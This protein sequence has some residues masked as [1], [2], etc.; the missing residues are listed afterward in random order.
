MRP[1]TATRKR[2]VGVPV[3]VDIEIQLRKV[4]GKLK[5]LPKTEKERAYIESLLVQLASAEEIERKVLEEY[6][7]LQA[8]VESLESKEPIDFLSWLETNP[9]PRSPIASALC[10]LRGIGLERE[11]LNKEISLPGFAEEPS[12]IEALAYTIGAFLATKCE[13]PGELLLAAS[14]KALQKS[15]RAIR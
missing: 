4:L 1:S 15:E 2:T 11:S 5:T 10:H 9:L 8:F 6:K 12:A 3:V 7:C 14:V 13:E